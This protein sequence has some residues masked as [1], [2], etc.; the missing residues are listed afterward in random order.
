MQGTVINSNRIISVTLNF[1][2]FNYET[3]THLK[4]QLH[5]FNAKT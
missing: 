4:L 1:F 2:F 3:T 5:I